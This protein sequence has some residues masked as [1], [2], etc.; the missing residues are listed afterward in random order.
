MKQKVALIDRRLITDFLYI[1]SPVSVVF[2]FFSI[3]LDVAEKEKVIVSVSIVAIL[4]ATYLLLWIRANTL[5]KVEF[6]VDNSYVVVKVGDIFKE[7][8]YKV[9]GFNEYFD[10]I[11][12]NKIISENT[13]NGIFLNEVETDINQ[14]D[15]LIETDGVLREKLIEI[16]EKRAHGKKNKFRLGSIIQYGEYLLTAFSKFDD[17][18]RAYLCMNDYVNFLLNFWNEIDIIYAGKSVSVPL[19]G[20]GVTRFKGFSNITDQEL[21]ELLLWSFKIS[22]IK[23][24]YPSKITIVIH[25]SRK[26]RINFYKLKGVV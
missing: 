9:I 3:V 25:E 10:T 7:Q 22:R 11:V 26:D 16:N 5:S 12:D 19:M 20:S 6:S 23:F 18:N 15:S 14:L 24:S 8:G 17:D 4:F 2:S 13:L 1:L 21:L